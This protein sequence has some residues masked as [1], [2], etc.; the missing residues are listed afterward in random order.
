MVFLCEIPYLTIL[1]V[2]LRPVEFYEITRP[3]TF[4][5]CKPGF[6][7]IELEHSALSFGFSEIEL[8]HSALPFCLA[9]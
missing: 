3:K 5:Y 4:V 6:S 7:E 2:T 8:E 9:S 1:T